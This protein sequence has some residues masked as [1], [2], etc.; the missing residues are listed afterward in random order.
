MKTHVLREPMRPDH[1]YALELLLKRVKEVQP[2]ADRG[3]ALYSLVVGHTSQLAGFLRGAH[4]EIC[5]II[6]ADDVAERARAA[7]QAAKGVQS[8]QV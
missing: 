1:R 8:A 4:D 7:Q 5:R 3:G 2:H 6:S